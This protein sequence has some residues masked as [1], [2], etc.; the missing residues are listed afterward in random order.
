MELIIKKDTTRVVWD[1]KTNTLQATRFVNSKV[2][3]ITTKEPKTIGEFAIRFNN[4]VGLSNDDFKLMS[5]IED[6]DIV[7][8]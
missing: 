1:S 5:D 7:I 4:L 8:D 3:T 6:I 2:F